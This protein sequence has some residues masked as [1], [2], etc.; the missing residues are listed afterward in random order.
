MIVTAGYLKLLPGP[1]EWMGWEGWERAFDSMGF[2]GV[3]SVASGRMENRS[4]PVS[5]YW[6]SQSDAV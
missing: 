1:D 6:G 5:S 4:E 2:F 3:E